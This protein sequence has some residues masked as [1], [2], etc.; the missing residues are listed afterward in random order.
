[1]QRTD[2]DLLGRQLNALAEAFDKKPVTVKAMEIWF[3][4]LREFPTERVMDVLNHWA[5]SHA[6]FPVPSEVWKIVN[7]R[8][9][10]VRE[11]RA[12]EEKKQFA[13][14]ER[15]GFK[16]PQGAKILREMWRLLGK[17]PPKH[18]DRTF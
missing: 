9:A 4:A 12:I 8:M 5:K 3:D 18:D 6:R 15:R 13:A 17:E 7:E 1:M 16:T 14:E 2:I 11:E 10:D